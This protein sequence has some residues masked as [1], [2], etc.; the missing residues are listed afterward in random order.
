MPFDI[1]AARRAGY[2]DAE[3][4]QY[5]AQNPRRGKMQV[6]TQGAET[7]DP[8]SYAANA[9]EQVDAPAP[10]VGP[11]ATRLSGRQAAEN[12]DIGTRVVGGAGTTLIDWANRAQQLWQGGTLNPEQQNRLETTQGIGQDPGAAVGRVAGTVATMGYPAAALQ[13]ILARGI[14]SI[15]PAALAG[16]SGPV[17]SGVVGAG[18]NAATVPVGQWDTET[19][20]ALRGGGAAMVGDL[21]ARGLSRIIQPIRQSPETERLLRE[22]IVPTP[23]QA[24]GPNSMLGRIEQRA[25]SVP[26]LGDVVTGAKMRAREEFNR[27]AMGRGMPPGEPVQNLGPQGIDDMRAAQSAGYDRVYGNRG[28]TFDMDPQFL[29]DAVASVQAPRIPMTPAS[30]Q[31]FRDTVQNLFQN[32]LTALQQ[33]HGSN[34]V[35]MREVKVS[36]ESELGSAIRRFEAGNASVQDRSIAEALRSFRQAVRGVMNRNVGPDGQIALQALDLSRFN[37]EALGNAVERARGQGGVFTPNQL[38]AATRNNPELRGLANDAQAVMGSTVPNSG[39]ADRMMQAMAMG[40]GGAAIALNP[41]VAAALAPLLG[42]TRA[43]ARYMVGDLVPGQAA[44]GGLLSRGAPLAGIGARPL[45]DLLN[46]PQ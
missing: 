2:S 39:S 4:S 11:D 10:I 29:R 26:V 35:P 20:N 27:A 8:A 41:Q 44:M 13:S 34:I 38:Q 46:E 40:S 19:A 3:I 22:G 14:A 33:R 36:I 43:G 18:L 12:A 28:V 42:Y 7:G 25:Q 21:A 15:S 37:R 45:A 31:Q 17:A 16:A 6:S 5:L 9:Q 32:Q 30:Q 1:E 23:G 24:A